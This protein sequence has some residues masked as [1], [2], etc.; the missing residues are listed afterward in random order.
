[1]VFAYLAALQNRLCFSA[2][3]LAGIIV[4]SSPDALALDGRSVGEY[5]SAGIG[6]ATAAKVEPATAP[7]EVKVRE[8]LLTVNARDVPLADVL[9]V[10]GEKAGFTVII[11]G[12]LSTP[13]T[14]SFTGVPLDKAIGRLV[15]KKNSWIMIYG[16]PDA[17]GRVSDPLELQV[18]GSRDT[19]TATVIQSTAITS[20]MAAP[21]SSPASLEDSILKDLASPDRDARMR[22]IGMLGR[23]KGENSIDIL[24]QVLLEEEDPSVRR[25]A[26][27]TLGRI[28]SDR[29]IDTLE[30][31]S[32]SDPDA[33]VR[34]AA[35]SALAR[36]E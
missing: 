33:A 25:H 11:R 23:L 19:G 30:E 20:N 13:V 21:E 10:I 16:P 17:G 1:M 18:Y 8:G 26:V 24:I 34:E 32:H 2:V 9:R 15:G 4:I 28:A 29:A 36:R 7:T 12:N 22:A 35:N 6:L 27:I 31:V 3:W 14:S 5:L